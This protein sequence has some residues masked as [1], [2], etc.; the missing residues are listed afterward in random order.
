MWVAV[1]YEWSVAEAKWA[2]AVADAAIAVELEHVLR[3]DRELQTEFAAPTAVRDAARFIGTNRLMSPRFAIP[4]DA[5]VSTNADRAGVAL[6]LWAVCAVYGAIVIS[7]RIARSAAHVA[8][9]Q[10]TVDLVHIQCT[11]D[12]VHAA[13]VPAIHIQNLE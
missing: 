5:T 6:L 8:P 10:C 4:A 1:L 12:R 2:R 11:V 7:R 9:V 13:H 3:C